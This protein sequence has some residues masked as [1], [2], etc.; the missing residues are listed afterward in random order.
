MFF[1]GEAVD[2]NQK[3]FHRLRTGRAVQLVIRG[4]IRISRHLRP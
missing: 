2:S 1:V 4:L 3:T